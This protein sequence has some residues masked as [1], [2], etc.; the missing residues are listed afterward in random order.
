ME[1]DKKI[2]TGDKA[3]RA[4]WSDVWEDSAIPL[5]IDPFD[6]GR[7]NYAIRRF[8]ALFLRIFANNETHEHRLLEIGCARSV[9]LPYFANQFGFKVTGLDYSEVGCM[10]AREILQREHVQG[11][12]VQSDLF[13]PHD[14]LTG[15]FDVVTSFGVAEHFTDTGKC[16]AAFANYL[17]PGG[18]MI[19]VIP[20]M[21]WLVGALQKLLDRSVYDVHVPL[22][23]SVLKRAHE[24]CGLQVQC[25]GY[26]LST[27]FGVLNVDKLPLT[28]ISSRL[29]QALASNLSRISKG[30]ALIED[31]S[32]R[33]PATRVLSP[34]IVC[35]ASKSKLR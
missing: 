9:W 15:I 19:T 28:N 6:K 12:I 21:T 2:E 24:Q 30:I 34:Y 25:C 18:R 1:H 20:N 22:S 35:V 13:Y 17:K 23:A 26:F 8:H 32:V 27:G 7:S 10:Q 4:Y 3:G 29:K 31:H 33:L 11:E 5:A 14:K 16:I